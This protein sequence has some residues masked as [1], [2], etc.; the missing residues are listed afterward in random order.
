M[1]NLTPKGPGGKPSKKPN[2]KSGKRRDNAPKRKMLSLTLFRLFVL[3]ML[4]APV[5]AAELHKVVVTY[6]SQNLYELL[7]INKGLYVKTRF[8]FQM[9]FLNNAVLRIDN[10]H[11]HTIGEITFDDGSKCVVEKILK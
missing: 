8:C 3:L 11:G 7:Y 9:V 2:K 1:T 6:K 10:R 4:V 5:Q